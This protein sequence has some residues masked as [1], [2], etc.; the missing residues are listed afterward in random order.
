MTAIKQ[1][2]TCGGGIIPAWRNHHLLK[3]GVRREGDFCPPQ[4]ALSPNHQKVK[5]QDSALLAIWTHLQPLLAPPHE[6]PKKEI[7]FHIKEDAPSYR[8]GRKTAK[9]I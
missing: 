8:V 5:C 3:R 7:G 2:F 1:P 4:A 9:R 6:E